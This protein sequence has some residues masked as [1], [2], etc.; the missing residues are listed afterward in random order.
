MSGFQDVAQAA[1]LRLISPKIDFTV[2]ETGDTGE[3]HAL[4]Q[5]Y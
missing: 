2:D 4:R 5:N 3:P 1:R